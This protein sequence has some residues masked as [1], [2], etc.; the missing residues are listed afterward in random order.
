MLTDL[1][2]NL[3]GEIDSGL[4]NGVMS[5]KSLFDILLLHIY[6]F[7]AIAIVLD[8]VCNG[9]TLQVNSFLQTD[10]YFNEQDLFILSVRFTVH[11]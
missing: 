10:F 8:H 5:N 11:F 7:L 9:P 2:L 4:I 6:S 3:K 1:H